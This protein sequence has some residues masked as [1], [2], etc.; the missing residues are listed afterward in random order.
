MLSEHTKMN[1]KDYRKKPTPTDILGRKPAQCVVDVGRDVYYQLCALYIYS[2]TREG[3]LSLKRDRPARRHN[4]VPG[5]L[6]IPPGQRPENRP[7]GA[8]T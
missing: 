7:V 5:L 2:A 4:I 1:F 6:H 3:G 8:L